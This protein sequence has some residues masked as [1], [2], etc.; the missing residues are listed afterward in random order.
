[1]KAAFTTIAC[2]LFSVILAS[3]NTEYDTKYILSKDYDYYL[4]RAKSNAAK[5][6]AV[7]EMA[8]YGLTADINS[9]SDPNPICPQI[10]G[11]CCGTKDQELINTYW[12]SDN[13]HQAGYMI[14]YL[15]MNKYLLG[16]VK[17]YQNIAFD[18]IERS[19][20]LRFQ[21]KAK[22]PTQAGDKGSGSPAEDGKPYSFDYHPMCEEA[23][24]KFNNLDFVDRRKAQQF[25][26]NLNKR[27]NF[28]QD[29]RRGFYCSLCNAKAKDYISSYRFG[30]TS[31]LWYSKDFC[32]MLFTQ[33]FAS[34][35]SI[36]KAYNPFLKA[37][38]Q[39]M[40]CI[41]P[42]NKGSGNNNNQ[43]A[44]KDNQ[45]SGAQL[46]VK[47][48][49][50]SLSVDLKVKNPLKDKKISEPMRKMFDNPLGISSKFGLEF[51]R[52]SDPTGT[53][54]ALKCM[55]FCEKFEM[56]KASTLLDGDLDALK[57]VYNNMLEYEFALE[58]PN[59]SVFEGDVVAL[60]RSVETEVAYLKG[61]YNFYRS[62]D[63][64]INFSQ[65]K[66]VFSLLFKG[67]NPMQLSQGTTL[68]FKYKGA[69]VWEALVVAVVSIFMLR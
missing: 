30:P 28:M 57:L 1:M 17:N 18:I 4:Q 3:A 27:A 48:N 14:A 59:T 49:P 5:N 64:K 58:S 32:Q 35:Y 19:T 12:E 66:I 13:R 10:Q 52:D 26:D 38:M 41:K 33:S 55:S 24:K 51:C 39:M 47:F 16:N 21:G 67:H 2:V 56:T 6:C 62:L 50:V 65:Y 37:L 45:A 40:M 34:V 63:S 43:A 53:F 7:N 11:N 60:K 36:Y 46:Q 68:E 44:G 9:Q 61:N 29:S 22:A 42:K 25:Y 31:R 15:H 69:A 23:A 8:A 20:K 54:F